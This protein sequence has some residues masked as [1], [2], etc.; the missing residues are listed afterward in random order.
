M[1]RLVL[2]AALAP[3]AVLVPFA[4]R[5]HEGDHSQNSW[6][7]ALLE[8]DHLAPVAMIAIVGVVAYRLWARK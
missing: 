4:A 5:A 6:L 7:H 1:Q 3:S 2:L 8:P